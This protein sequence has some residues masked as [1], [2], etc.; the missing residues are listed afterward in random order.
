MV[1]GEFE[2]PLA[3]K[4]DSAPGLDCLLCGVYRSACGIG[5]KFLCAAY[6]ACLQERLS[7]LVSEPAV[8]FLFLSPPNFDAQGHTI[9]SHEALRPLTLCSCDCKVV[10][11]AMCSG[12]RRY[13]IECVH[14]S[15]RCVTQRIMTDN[16]LEIETAAIALGTRFS[17]DLGILLPHFSCAYPGVDHRWIFLVLK[18]ASVPLV[19]RLFL[20][21]I[22][23]DSVTSVE[24]AGA[25]RGQS[26]SMSGVR[27]GRPASGSF[28]TAAFDTVQ[29]AHDSRP[30]A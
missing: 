2:E 17:D 27:Q 13:S 26:T 7:L 28:F 3:S 24:H 23:N 6:R 1:L 25:V 5:A 10:T 16:I 15:Q 22:Q 18:R 4:R 9:R 20:R 21:G 30:T 8:R 12:L 19:L 29:V 14:P 11:A